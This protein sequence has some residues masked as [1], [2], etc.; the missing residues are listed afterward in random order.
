VLATL[1]A[2]AS[3]NAAP[4]AVRV[5]LPYANTGLCVAAALGITFPFNLA[6]GI[7]LYGWWVDWLVVR[8]A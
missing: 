7:P 2:S 6:F 4:A 3:Y 5:A 1:T 8:G